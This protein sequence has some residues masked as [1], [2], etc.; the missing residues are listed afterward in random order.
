MDG[1]CAGEDVRDEVERVQRIVLEG[2]PL[3]VLLDSGALLTSDSSLEKS[4]S[5]KLGV[6]GLPIHV[7]VM[8]GHS[9]ENVRSMLSGISDVQIHRQAIDLVSLGLTVGIWTQDPGKIDACFAWYVGV[10]ITPAWMHGCQQKGPHATETVLGYLGTTFV[11]ERA[12]AA[13]RAASAQ[14]GIP[15]DHSYA[16]EPILSGITRQVASLTTNTELSG[17]AHGKI[18]SNHKEYTSLLQAILSPLDQMVA[19]TGAFLAAPPPRTPTDPNYAFFWQRDAGNMAIALAR[20]YARAI[21]DAMSHRA[22][23]LCEGYVD[24]VA[25]LPSRPGISVG[26]L[27]VSR[28]SLDGDPIR[29]YGSPQND[30]PATTVLAVDAVCGGDIERSWR[31]CKPYLDYLEGIPAHGL[32]FDPWEFSVGEIF[33]AT[34]LTCRALHVGVR[35][36]TA[37][38][39]TAACQRY[40]HKELELQRDVEA[41]YDNE[42]GS[43]VAGQSLVIPWMDALT[44]IDSAVIGSI[45]C[46]YDPSNTWLDVDDPRVIAT[47]TA[48]ERACEARWPVNVAWRAAGNLGMGIGRFPE[49]MNDGIGSTGGNPW[50]V[51]TLWMAQYYLRRAQRLGPESTNSGQFQRLVNQADG[52]LSFVLHHVPAGRVSEQIDGSTGHPRGMAPLGWA[53]GELAVTLMLRNVVTGDNVLS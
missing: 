42:R 12:G 32:T 44:K 20:V 34:Y 1:G 2:A 40:S 17:V 51:T 14:A 45:V 13:F 19:M 33:Y 8:A 16:A 23:A 9:D 37:V 24:F 5:A 26:D 43:F 11:Q 21:E 25:A 39:D 48:I 41:L 3:A 7:V 35:L 29:E 50:T 52:Y 47:V 49:D 28:F 18:P 10:G 27:G 22:R 53:H 30:G 4:I 36:A 6:L 38:A 31:V 46:A 15:R